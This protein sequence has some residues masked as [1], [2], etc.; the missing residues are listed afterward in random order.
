MDLTSFLIGIAGGLVLS[1]YLVKSVITDVI[2]RLDQ[3]SVGD[4]VTKSQAK[5]DQLL[6]E[7]VNGIYYVWDETTN[8]FIGQRN[9]ILE[10]VDM[11]GIKDYTVTG[12]TDI[13]EQFKAAVKNG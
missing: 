5:L 9:T 11:I 12:D 8:K 10:V 4:H 13:I 3:D 7:E 6:I 2:S 1:Y